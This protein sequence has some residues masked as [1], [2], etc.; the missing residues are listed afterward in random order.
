ME[1]GLIDVDGH[2][3]PNLALMK[4]S[5][6]HKS[7]GDN[8]KWVNYFENYDKVYISKIFDFT[9]DCSTQINSNEII[10]G[11]SGYDPTV[12][13]DDNIENFNPDY[14]IYPQYNFSI[15]LFSRGCIRACKFCIVNKKE[16]KIYPI[17]P[18]QLNSKGKHIEVLDNNFFA[19]PEWESA[20]DW[21]V[22]AKQ[23]VNLNGVDV[24]IITDKQCEALN[25]IKHFKQ[26]HIAWDNAKDDLLP[27]IKEMT[28]IVKPHKIMC[29]VLIGFNST[30]Q[31]DEYRV[32]EIDKLDRQMGIWELPL[33]RL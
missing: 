2:N 21:L 4:I 8:V 20:V 14:S 23:P 13:L 22:S 16:G 7:I 5:A 6:Y 15:Q 31:E 1:I 33:I 11:G 30:Q 19:N 24:R 28:K 26:I 32:S 17:K 29:Y 9:K 25:K 3:Y 12:K 27:K 18:M 10:K